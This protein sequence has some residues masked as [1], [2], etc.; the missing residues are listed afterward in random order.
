MTRYLQVQP[1]LAL[2]TAGWRQ[3]GE[4]H[5]RLRVLTCLR[6]LG[7]ELQASV[8]AG[9]GS[10]RHYLPPASASPVTNG[11]HLQV[12]TTRS[13][14]LC[15]E[16]DSTNYKEVAGLPASRAYQRVD[17][18][19]FTGASYSQANPCA[20]AAGILQPVALIF[21][22]DDQLECGRVIIAAGCDCIRCCSW[23]ICLQHTPR[24]AAHSP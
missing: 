15:L 20:M 17:R 1:C 12:R 11:C 6:N 7:P 24:L 5:H 10:S 13:F 23:V 2:Q 9:G 19:R 4:A 22:D 18:I 14:N 8:R 16:E 3:R 21:T